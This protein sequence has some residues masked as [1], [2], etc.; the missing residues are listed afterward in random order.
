VVEQATAPV[1][2]PDNLAPTLRWAVASRALNGADATGDSYVVVPNPRGMVVAVIDGLGH[3]REAA[4][5]AGIAAAEVTKRAHEPVASIMQCCHQA[6][7]QTRGAVMSVAAFD[8]ID[9]TMTWIGIGD[10]A[11]ILVFGD[12][13]ARP[14]QTVLVHRGG[15]VGSSMPSPRPWIVPISDGDTLIFA[16]DG[17]KTGFESGLLLHPE[18]ATTANQILDRHSKGSDDAMVL[19]ARFVSPSTGT[20]VHR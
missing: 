20:P 16:T 12:S 10:V 8:F 2:R 7:L 17:V 13:S 15:I 6:L 1:D 4:G 3:G 5:P 18:P 19:V 14:S 11:G 9:R